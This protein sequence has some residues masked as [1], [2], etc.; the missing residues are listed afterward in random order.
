M[1][2]DRCYDDK[3]YNHCDCDKELV[4]RLGQLIE[5]GQLNGKQMAAAAAISTWFSVQLCNYP[6]NIGAIRIPIPFGT[7]GSLAFI[8]GGV[9]SVRRAGKSV[10]KKIRSIF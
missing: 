4:Q 8:S 1:N 7:G 6:I 9:K 3:G 10:W 2:H 5:S